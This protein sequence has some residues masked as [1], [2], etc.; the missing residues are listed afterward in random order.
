MNEK[1]LATLRK[2]NEESRDFVKSCFR[3][4]L[5]IILKDK[6]DKTINVTRLCKI[7]GVSRM[8]FYRNYKGIDDVLVDEITEF[9]QALL[10]VIGDDAYDNWLRLFCLAEERRD[11]LLAIIEAGFE[12]KILEV[13]MSLLP[14]EETKRTLQA[15]WFSLF[16]TLM[17]KWL[18]EGKPR[19]PEEMA[20][21]AFKFTKGIPLSTNE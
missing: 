7:A 13:F 14:K 5:M 3:Y 17:V 16:Y 4:A 8:A 21:I 15:I 19:T 10:E 9:G 20:K 11:N 2:N 12:T 1:Q 18:K 6:E